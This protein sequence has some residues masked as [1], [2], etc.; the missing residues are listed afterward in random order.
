[1]TCFHQLHPAATCAGG[2][3]GGHGVRLHAGRKSPRKV[4]QVIKELYQ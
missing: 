3:Y 2:V 1:V 4:Y